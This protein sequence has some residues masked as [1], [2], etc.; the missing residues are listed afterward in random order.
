MFKNSGDLAA[1][2]WC[3]PPP[4]N[5]IRRK[6]EQEGEQDCANVD[7]NQLDDPLPFKLIYTNIVLSYNQYI[8]SVYGKGSSNCLWSEREKV[9][10]VFIVHPDKSTLDYFHTTPYCM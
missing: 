9:C 2:T 10:V 5:K 3:S 8:I 1:H 4:L 7:H 6:Q